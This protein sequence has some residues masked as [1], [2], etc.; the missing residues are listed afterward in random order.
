MLSYTLI[1]ISRDEL[2]GLDKAHK[3]FPSPHKLQKLP[4]R[5]KAE[6]SRQTLPSCGTRKNADWW[7]IVSFVTVGQQN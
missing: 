7:K 3:V 5:M 1:K 4:L 6:Q 2:K